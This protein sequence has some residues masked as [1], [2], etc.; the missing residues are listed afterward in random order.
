MQKGISWVSIP[1]MVPEGT[2]ADAWDVAVTRRDTGVGQHQTVAADVRSVIF[3]CEEGPWTASVVRLNPDGN[4]L[5]AVSTKD[6]DVVGAPQMIEIQVAGDIT[7]SDVV[8]GA[9]TVT[10]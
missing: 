9:G 7:V 6:F 1:L 2:I 10:A 5:G 3:E 4:Q 8:E